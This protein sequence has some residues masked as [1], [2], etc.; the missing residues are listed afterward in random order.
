[1]RPRRGICRF[2]LGNTEGSSACTK[3]PSTTLRVDILRYF[4]SATILPFGLRWNGCRP[5][6]VLL[7]QRRRA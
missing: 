4:L 5:V 3:S 2:V 6:S 1:V 7:E